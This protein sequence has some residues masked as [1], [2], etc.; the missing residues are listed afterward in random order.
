MS[1][2]PT[3]KVKTVIMKKAMDLRAATLEALYEHSVPPRATTSQPRQTTVVASTSVVTKM[4]AT[5]N[6]ERKNPPPPARIDARCWV[7]LAKPAH[8]VDKC[9]TF[10]AMT[11]AERVAAAG[12]ACRCW[13]CLGFHPYGQCSSGIICEATTCSHRDAH[14]SLL[15]GAPRYHRAAS[16][17]SQPRETIAAALPRPHE[18]PAPPLLDIDDVYQQTI[19]AVVPLLTPAM[20]LGAKPK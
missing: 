12:I 1:Q 2:H 10:I 14:H 4:A 17:T 16:A 9:A 20:L 15:H 3:E 19:A 5:R 11:M 13:V 7:C 8:D 18:P 6:T